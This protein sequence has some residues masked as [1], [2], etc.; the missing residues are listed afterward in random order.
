MKSS[1]DDAPYLPSNVDFVAANN[2]LAGAED[3][4][5]VLMEASYMVLGLGGVPYRPSGFRFHRSSDP[6]RRQ[7]LRADAVALCLDMCLACSGVAPES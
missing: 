1:R 5:R 7:G 2:G 3:V 4:R 6:A